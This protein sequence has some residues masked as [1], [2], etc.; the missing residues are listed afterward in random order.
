VSF[1]YSRYVKRS[2]NIVTSGPIL[3]DPTLGLND[4]VPGPGQPPT[5]ILNPNPGSF[6]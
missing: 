2:V 6:A 1:G 4:L 5:T 3:G